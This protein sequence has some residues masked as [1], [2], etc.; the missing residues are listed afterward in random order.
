MIFKRRGISGTQ[1][2]PDD[3]DA[4]KLGN[5]LTLHTRHAIRSPH[6]VLLASGHPS[7]HPDVI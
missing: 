3:E 6:Y 1:A 5:G 7:R 2:D 4:V